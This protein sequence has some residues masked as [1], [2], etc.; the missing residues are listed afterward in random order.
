MN[1][2]FV[3]YFIIKFIYFL[4]FTSWGWVSVV[5]KFMLRHSILHYT[6]M[7]TEFHKS[8]PYSIRVYVFYYSFQYFTHSYFIIIYLY[9]LYYLFLLFISFFHLYYLLF[10]SIFY[11][12]SIL[13]YTKYQY[14]ILNSL[15]RN[16]I[17]L[18]K[19]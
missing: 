1:T 2:I 6:W 4:S 17:N 15:I 7:P 18:L 9:Y 12:Y 14:L 5:F 3:S 19:Y 8:I 13:Y 10:I 11:L 16:D